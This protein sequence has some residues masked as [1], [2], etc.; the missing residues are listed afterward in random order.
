MA[1]LQY[2]TISRRT[3]EALKV[4]KDTVGQRAGRV[5]CAGL[6]VGEQILCRSDPGRRRGGEAGDGGPSWGVDS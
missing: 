1:K 6:C 5:R 4:A 2:K 3:V